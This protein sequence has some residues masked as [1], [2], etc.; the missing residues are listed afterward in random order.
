M[1]PDH[2]SI[3]EYFRREVVE[4]YDVG[5]FYLGINDE[6][7]NGEG[8]V[9]KTADVAYLFFLRYIPQYFLPFS[10]AARRWVVG[11]DAH[12]TLQD[13][14]AAILFNMVKKA[15]TMNVEVLLAAVGSVKGVVEGMERIEDVNDKEFLKL[16][17]RR[18]THT[19]THTP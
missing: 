15:V 9:G 13:F 18:G 3:G 14:E 7:W 16:Q 19:N 6:E 8:R 5:R 4:K 2:R 11:G 17:V 1:D 12:D 10:K